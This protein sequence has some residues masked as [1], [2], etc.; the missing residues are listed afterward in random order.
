MIY[1]STETSFTYNSSRP[2][3]FISTLHHVLLLLVDESMCNTA[4]IPRLT[5][6]IVCFS[7]LK[8]TAVMPAVNLEEATCFSH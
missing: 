7:T 8:V 5:R 4:K 1:H 3:Q 2:T 6:K